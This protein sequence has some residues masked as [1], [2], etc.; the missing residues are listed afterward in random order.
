MVYMNTTLQCDCIFAGQ[1]S[2]GWEGD[3][4]LEAKFCSRDEDVVKEL[5]QLLDKAAKRG[6]VISDVTVKLQDELTVLADFLENVAKRRPPGK[7]LIQS[8]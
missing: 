3:R 4:Q 8:S 2:E 7:L 6:E 1:L 5:D